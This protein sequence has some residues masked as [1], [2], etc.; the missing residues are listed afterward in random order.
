[1]NRND[2]LT[3]IKRLALTG[4]FRFTDKAL[5]EMERDGIDEE[6]VRE[7]IVNAS[8][9]MK[10]IRST[11]PHT[12][13]REYLYII[14]GQSWSGILIYTKGRIES[15]NGKEIFYVLISSKRFLD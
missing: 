13:I 15:D 2:L 3:R 10:T 8:F 5:N 12:Q 4:R 6:M 9:I 14:V 1:M 11:V 7:V